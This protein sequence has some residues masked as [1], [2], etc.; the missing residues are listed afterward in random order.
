MSSKGSSSQGKGPVK[1]SVKESSANPHEK[2]PNAGNAP[3]F[4]PLMKESSDEEP[5]ESVSDSLKKLKSMFAHFLDRQNE[6]EV[7]IRNLTV[8]LADLKSVNEKIPLI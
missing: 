1:A 5:N 4:A 7:A 3:Y 2:A 8:D 6:S